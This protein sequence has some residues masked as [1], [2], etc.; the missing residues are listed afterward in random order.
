VIRGCIAGATHPTIK[1]E[2]GVKYRKLNNF[3][4]SYRSELNTDGGDQNFG[5]K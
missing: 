5:S 1:S 4:V 2:T 3:G